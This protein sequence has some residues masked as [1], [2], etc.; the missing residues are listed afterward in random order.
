MDYLNFRTTSKQK[1]SE[2]NLSEIRGWT[3]ECL[4]EV[5]TRIDY[6][7]SDY[8]KPENKKEFKRIFLNSSII[9]IGAKTKI[10]RNIKTFDN[11]IIDKIQR[12]LSIRNAFAHTPISESIIVNVTKNNKE[13]STADILVTSEMEIMNSSGELKKKNAKDLV[14]EFLDLYNE[15]RKYLNNFNHS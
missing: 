11:K 2:F 3:I 15:I 13:E 6:I 14:I 4:Y 12:L 8:F 7:I 1:L 9:S 10:L 5:E